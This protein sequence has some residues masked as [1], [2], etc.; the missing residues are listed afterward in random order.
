LGST[1]RPQTRPFLLALACASFLA[2]CRSDHA[3]LGRK[4]F[5][6]K[7][8]HGAVEE[9]EWAT[10]R[11]P[12][13]HAS[14]YLLGRALARTTRRGEAKATL[15][16]V[17]KV[18]AYR[19][20]ASRNLVV[21]LC[22]EKDFD[23]AD[24]VVA[25]DLADM[26]GDAQALELRGYVAMRRTEA[27]LAALIKGLVEEVGDGPINWAVRRMVQ[28]RTLDEGAF[29]AW[30]RDSANELERRYGLRDRRKVEVAASRTRE[31]ALKAKADFEAAAAKDPLA[32]RSLFEL[33]QMAVD[34]NETDAAKKYLMPVINLDASALPDAETRAAYSETRPKAVTLLAAHLEERGY[35]SDSIAILAA[36]ME[37]GLLDPGQQERLGLQYLKNK[38]FAEAGKVADALIARDPRST[39]GSYLRGSVAAQ[40]GRKEDAVTY[41]NRARIRNDTNPVINA[42]L[43]RALV[44]VGR[45]TQAEEALRTAL[46]HGMEG[47]VDLV[48]D[49]AAVLAKES[50][51]IR[52]ANYLEER[53]KSSF[54]DP[55]SPAHQRLLGEIRKYYT[56][57]GVRADS[58]GTART[59]LAL[60]PEN[61]FLKL[62][63]AQLE[64][65]KG[66]STIALA[67]CNEVTSEFPGLADGWVLKSQILVDMGRG[68]DAIPALE[69]AAALR[70]D[71]P[72]IPWMLGRVAM[73]DKRPDDARRHL[74]KALEIDPK[75]GGPRLDL[76]DVELGA[77][78]PPGALSQAQILLERFPEDPRVHRGIGLA[79]LAMKD[80]RGAVAP[81]RKATETKPSDPAVRIKLATA[82]LDSGATAEAR[83]VLVNMTA[84]ASLPRPA[85]KEAARTLD[86]AGFYTEA[87][88][89]WQALFASANSESE[90]LEISAAAFR[91]QIAAGKVTAAIDELAGMILSGRRDHAGRLFLMAAERAGFH[92]EAAAQADILRTHDALD[93][94]SLGAAWRAHVAT[95]EWHKA[96][97]DLDDLARVKPEMIGDVKIERASAL[98]AAGKLPEAEAAAEQ[99]ASRPADPARALRLKLDLALARGDPA[100]IDVA[101]A[102]N[103]AASPSD[104]MPRLAVARAH[105]AAG[106]VEQAAALIAG[107][108]RMP[109]EESTLLAAAILVA[110]GNATAAAGLTEANLDRGERVAEA[111]GLVAVVLGTAPPEATR[112]ATYLSRIGARDARGAQAAVSRLDVPA[113]IAQETWMLLAEVAHSKTDVLVPLAQELARA[114]LFLDSRVLAER[115]MT[116]MRSLAD[117]AASKRKPIDLIR[118]WWR[119][120]L[121]DAKA[122]ADLVVPMMEKEGRNPAVLLIASMA[123]FT[124]AGPDAPARLLTSPG[125]PLPDV[126]LRD[127]GRFLASKG[128]H[129]LALKAWAKLAQPGET[130][131]ALAFLVFVERRELREAQA[132]LQ[133]LPESWQQK[134]ALAAARLW[135]LAQSETSRP[136]AIAGIKS[137]LARPGALDGVDPFV[138]YEAAG[139]AGQKTEAAQI[140]DQSLAA[141]GFAVEPVA[142]FVEILRRTATDD[143]T[144]HRL[145]DRLGVLDPS[146]KLRQLERRAIVLK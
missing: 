100:A 73:R 51:A 107:L 83:T 33:G 145:E 90:R 95:K 106:R 61:T 67:R 94:E 97:E 111:Q 6:A 131:R 79:K 103:I 96:I 65:E 27:D 56:A 44:A 28:S 63:V 118:A 9:L 75:L 99:A 19:K 89:A 74:T 4:R 88:A 87:A 22:R 68:A 18:H 16:E 82:L 3:D 45:T 136:A 80:A 40:A 120:E 52:A 78:N 62:K 49:Y 135:V 119:L 38:Q 17:R 59:A 70:N 21:V 2:G 13:D 140:L 93:S 46:V 116:T 7:D 125:G 128:N 109:D 31:L 24:A 146:G 77:N 142:R 141:A 58:L 47:D 113:S 43:G 8:Y 143:A 11:H 123:G 110:G 127:L 84:D 10:K 98:L 126:F 41:F 137:L 42:A 104:P 121:G 25:E 54:R 29:K 12:E 72:N 130:D 15:R 64:H 76:I 102:A 35:L 37:K 108:G 92:R 139:A 26:P 14:R 69:K 91:S 48:T 122:A 105:A 50:D 134:Q 138:L 53:L 112:F 133:S 101:L 71:D 20:G 81:L 23:G 32:F 114:R 132:A 34:R 129:L 39:W 124:L 1:L 86:G 85:R 30:T 144:L 5:E 55:A 115:G 66:F 57:S 60:H 117:L 36:E